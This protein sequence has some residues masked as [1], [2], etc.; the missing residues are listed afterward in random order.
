MGSSLLNLDPKALSL[1]SLAMAVG[2][3]FSSGD[4]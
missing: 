3:R 4:A 2:P 1:A